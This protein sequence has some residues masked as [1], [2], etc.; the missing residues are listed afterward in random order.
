MSPLGIMLDRVGVGNTP[1]IGREQEVQAVS[2]LLK[3]PRIRPLALTGTGGVGKTR[4]GLQVA[5]DLVQ[6]FAHG[7]CL[8]SLASISDTEGVIAAI[9]QRL[10]CETSSAQ[11]SVTLIML[12]MS[13]R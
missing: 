3:Q 1:L 6:D 7:T 13:Q 11:V 2:T 9:A 10:G 8:V 12:H 5:E 4:L